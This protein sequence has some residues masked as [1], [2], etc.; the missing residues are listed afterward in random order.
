MNWTL[1]HGPDIVLA[2]WQHFVLVGVSIAI[3][4]AISLALGIWTARRPRAY[5]CVL[6]VTGAIYAVPS[7]ALFALLI[8]LV[9]LGRVPAII[10]LTAYSLLILVRNVA[11]GLREVPA[12]ILEA[13]EGMGFGRGQRLVQVELPLALPVIVAGLRIAT[14]TVIGIATIAAYINAGGLG[15]LVFAGI[16]QRFAEKIVVGG[17]LTSLLAISADFSLSRLE[18]RLRA[19]R[20]S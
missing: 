8:P 6:G 9:G 18:R 13:A 4:F 15:A 17:L 12:E 5:T 19:H 1:T 14:V 2:I 20:A 7:L 3:A 16:D 10:G 11:T